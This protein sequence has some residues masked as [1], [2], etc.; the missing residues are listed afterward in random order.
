[1]YTPCMLCYAF[2][3]S[4]MVIRSEDNYKPDIIHWA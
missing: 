1:M 2:L 3:S 4:L